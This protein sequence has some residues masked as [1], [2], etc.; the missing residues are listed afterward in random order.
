M[1]N[2]TTMCI[3]RGTTRTWWTN[4]VGLIICPHGDNHTPFIALRA[5][6]PSA[7]NTSILISLLLYQIILLV[8]FYLEYKPRLINQ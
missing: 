2:V 4:F 7:T 1:K 3:I 8:T 6:I 5:L